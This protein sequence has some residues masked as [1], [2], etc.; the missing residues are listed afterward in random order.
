M[1]HRSHPTSE[2]SYGVVN[3]IVNN[4]LVNRLI[5][6]GES[7]STFSVL[8]KIAE[9]IDESGKF[10]QTGPRVPILDCIRTLIAV[11]SRLHA[12][13]VH[14]TN[15]CGVSILAT[16]FEALI[17]SL[18][19]V[20]PDQQDCVTPQPKLI[21]TEVKEAT[22][23]HATAKEI[24]DAIAKDPKFT[25]QSFLKL[26][27]QS[28]NPQLTNDLLADAGPN[29]NGWISSGGTLAPLLVVTPPTL[30][31]A[32]TIE[33]QGTISNVDDSNGT[34]SLE[35]Y[36]Y[37]NDQTKALLAH[38]PAKV[39]LHF[40]KDSVELEDSLL[41]QYRSE[42]VWLKVTATCATHPRHAK[43]TSLTLTEIL[44]NRN[45]LNSCHAMLKQMNFEFGPSANELP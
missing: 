38:H 28:P 20:E 45:V 32:R 41:I 15:L 5:R 6:E 1:R 14:P 22:R 29:H 17:V 44:V 23:S 40:D 43:K 24:S 13:H 34:A 37:R 2:N 26:L 39:D 25:M 4:E 11:A 21:K 8:P 7:H 19:R 30:P 33:L 12:S 9:I 3:M 16:A 18:E 42:P 10:H 31:A 36:E 35:I 27:A